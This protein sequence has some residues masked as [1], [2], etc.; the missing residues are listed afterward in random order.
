MTAVDHGGAPVVLLSGPPASGKSTLSRAILAARPGWRRFAVRE[1]FT[2]Q[3]LA[4][5]PLGRR[6][7]EIAARQPFLPDDF[8]ASALSSWM[9]EDPG[10]TGFLL[11]GF[12]RNAEQT[13]LL[14]DLLAPRG[15]RIDAFLYLDVPDA[16][17]HAR[18]AART[19]CPSCHGPVYQPVDAG[20]DAPCEVCGRPL[21]RRPDDGDEAFDRR[22]R[23]HRSAVRPLL[24]EF[25][26]RGCLHTI[27][28]ELP[29]ERVL[30][31]AETV[32]AS[33]AHPRSHVAH[34]GRPS[35]S[36]SST[37]TA[38]SIVSADPTRD[39]PAGER[40]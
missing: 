12:P 22:L 14:D 28:G 9:D 15:L 35:R 6:S 3:T 26:K 2:A 7:A 33:P 1:F 32:L 37:S 20:R 8:V 19:M 40:G 24:D 4:G 31:H 27:D 18:R 10:A 23:S 11:E 21:V 34:V 39:R 13:R 36:L 17:A 16:V 25:G 30:A 38:R 5:T 29:R